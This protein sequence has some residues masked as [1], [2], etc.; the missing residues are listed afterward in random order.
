MVKARSKSVVKI[1]V[2]IGQNVGQ[3]TR[4]N[5]KILMKSVSCWARM[6]IKGGELHSSL[7]GL[8]KGG[9]WTVDGKNRLQN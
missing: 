3:S 7:C 4:Q 9:H 6:A 8:R 1:V 2:Q 5:P